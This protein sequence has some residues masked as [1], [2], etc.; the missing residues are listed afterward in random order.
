MLC[1]MATIAQ[2][3]NIASGRTIT[4]HE[5]V[6]QQARISFVGMQEYIVDTLCWL[7]KLLYDVSIALRAPWYE[8]NACAYHIA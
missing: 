7:S 1:P 2:H 6:S 3:C 4:M 5:V 8:Y